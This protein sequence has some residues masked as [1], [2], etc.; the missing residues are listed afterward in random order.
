MSNYQ[1]R[2]KISFRAGLKNGWS[3]LGWIVKI[4]IPISF[5]VALLQWSGWLSKAGLLLNPL[6]VLINLPGEAA[7][8]IIIGML[9]GTYGAIAAMVVM[10]FTLEQMTL[11]AVF[12]V[13]AHSL[14]MEGTVQHKSGMSFAKIV[15]FRIIAA[16]L[17]ILIVSQFFGDT[18]RSI[19]VAPSYVVPHTQLLEAL[20]SWAVDTTILLLKLF[21]I[22]MLIMILLAVSRSMGW[23]EYLIKFFKPWM[24][25]LGVPQRTAPIWV[26]AA[27]F[28]LLMGGATIVE[29]TRRE[30]LPREEV[31]YL[32]T[33]IGINHSM[34]EDPLI[35]MAIGLNA[36]WLVIP[37]LFMAIIAVQ[38]YRAANHLSKRFRH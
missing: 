18:S 34:L 13:I 30:T 31:Q 8:P 16:V 25:I 7:I 2:L 5:L 22:I 32:H 33:S 37:R 19:I 38:I 35:Y 20:T 11:I 14:I 36:F 10:P 17:T 29:E 15:T 12:N 21:V 23:T 9:V 27:I 26:T 6:M 1:D 4:T 28:G 3:S 24:T